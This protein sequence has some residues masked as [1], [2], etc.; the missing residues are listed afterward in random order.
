MKEDR[1]PSDMKVVRDKSNFL[2]VQNII[3]CI[4]GFEFQGYMKAK[5]KSLL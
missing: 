3:L 2:A 5:K 1:R 4:A